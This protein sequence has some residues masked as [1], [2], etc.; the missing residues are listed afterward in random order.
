LLR[1]RLADPPSLKDLA[2]IVGTNQPR[3]SRSF[4]ALFGTTVYGYLREARMQRAR[5][6]VTGTRM[7]VKSIALE[8]GYRSTSDLTRAVKER[9]GMTPSEL[10]ERT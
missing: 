9:F 2:K 8:V 5:E 6:L 7:P 1:A 4:R 3:L 10:R